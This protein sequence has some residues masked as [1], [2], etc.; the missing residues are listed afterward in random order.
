MGILVLHPFDTI[1]VR[2]QTQSFL[3]PA[4]QSPLQC[5]TSICRQES[6]WGLYKGLPVPLACAAAIESA[7]FG[8]YGMALKLLGGHDQSVMSVHSPLLTLSA[9]AVAGC[10]VS[11][12]DTPTDLVKVRLQ[13]ETRGVT[14]KGEASRIFSGPLRWLVKIHREEGLL[15]GLYRGL[16]VGMVRAAVDLSVYFTSWD[17]FRSV[18]TPHGGRPDDLGFVRMCVAGALTGCCSLIVSFPFDL[19]KARMQA[20]YTREL[21]YR[22]TWDCFRKSFREGGLSVFY[23][24]LSPA[25]LTAAMSDALVLSIVSLYLS[26]FEKHRID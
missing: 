2:L 22:S 12:I 1:T 3:G 5:F 11:L 19:I 21:K 16:P 18:F 9:G 17:W 20:D 24:G 14:G 6:I 23:R 25:M 8:V 15:R 7:G 13:V 26:Y 10:A 4:Y